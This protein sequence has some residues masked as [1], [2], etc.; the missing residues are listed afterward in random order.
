[1]PVC[2]AGRVPPARRGGRAGWPVVLRSPLLQEEQ[3][4]L[5]RAL[6]T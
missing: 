6:S 4:G 2:S 3:H 1:M 5:G